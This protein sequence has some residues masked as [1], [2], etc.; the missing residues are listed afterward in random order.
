VSRKVQEVCLTQAAHGTEMLEAL[1]FVDSQLPISFRCAEW[2]EWFVALAT[3][4]EDVAD[5]FAEHI[6]R[7]HPELA[8][9]RK[10]KLWN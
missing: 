2:D 7:R 10:G 1:Y 6:C 3:D 8:Y 4:I 5:E 9:C